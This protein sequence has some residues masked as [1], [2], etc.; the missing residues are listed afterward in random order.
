[1]IGEVVGVVDRPS[2]KSVSGATDWKETGEVPLRLNRKAGLHMKWNAS[3]SLLTWYIAANAL[4]VATFVLKLPF[5]VFDPEMHLETAK[6]FFQDAWTLGFWRNLVKPDMGYLV[7]IPRIVTGTAVDLFGFVELFPQVAGWVSA[8]A[9]AFFATFLIFAPC[10][11]LIQ[12]DCVRVVTA[13]FLGIAVLLSGIWMGEF[14]YLHNVCYGGV[15]VLY[16]LPFIKVEEVSAFMRWS[17]ALLGFL[18][19]TSKPFFSVFLPAYLYFTVVA[20]RRADSRRLSVVL[21][22]AVGFAAQL[23]VMAINHSESAITGFERPSILAVVRDTALYLPHLMLNV[24]S[25]SWVR[26]VIWVPCGLLICLLMAMAALWRLRTDSLRCQ[27]LLQVVVVSG[28]A[29]FLT[30][31]TFGPNHG[32]VHNLSLQDVVP[33]PYS[34]HFFVPVIGIYLGTLVAIDG[35]TPSRGLRI[36]ASLACIA[37]FVSTGFL[38]N[39]VAPFNSASPNKL[40]AYSQWRRYVPLLKDAEFL[41]PINPYPWIIRNNLMYLG[42]DLWKPQAQPLTSVIN[43]EEYSKGRPWLIRGIILVNECF[44]A[45]ATCEEPAGRAPFVYAEARDS[46]EKV[47]GRVRAMTRSNYKYQYFVFPRKLA[48]ETIR[49]MNKDGTPLKVFPHIRFVGTQSGIDPNTVPFS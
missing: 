10:R 30:L 14:T 4:I 13:L 28:G 43:V 12:H 34:R 26:G 22:P 44:P 31:L 21:L 39:L 41:I 1:M 46:S 37:C 33:I 29:M 27:F 20:I 35:V 45:M 23:L 24:F 7:S 38:T 42:E 5:L 15:I 25:P 9:V 18:L 17:L 2:P 48:V 8:L 36:W 40:E 47:V 49:F 3:R 19:A 11:S 32:V 16:L 6:T